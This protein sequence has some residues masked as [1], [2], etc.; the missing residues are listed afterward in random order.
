MEN[1]IGWH[2]VAP[3]KEQLSQAVAELKAAA[4]SVKGAA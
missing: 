3:T 4:A 2:G 1:K